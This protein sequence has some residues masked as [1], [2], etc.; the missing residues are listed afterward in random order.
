MMKDLYDVIVI[1]GGQAGLAAAYHLQKAELNFII[2]E[3]NS[4]HLGSWAKYYDSLKLF[5]PARYSALP[6]MKFPGDPDRYPTRNEVVQYLHA[7]AGHYQF[8]IH[9]GT[10]VEDIQKENGSFIITAADNKRYQ[11][12]AIICASGPFNNPYLPHITNME[13]FKGTIL[14]SKQYSNH[15]KYK[16]QRIIVVGGGSSAV[17]IAIELAK[18]ANV[19]I[20][21]RKPL[22]FVPQTFLGK[23]IHFWITVLGLDQS[24]WG[25]WLLG[26]NTTG[27]L[28]TGAYQRA[29]EQNKPN[30][31]HMFEQFSEEGVIWG[32]GTPEKVDTVLF[33]TGYLPNFTYLRNLNVLNSKGEP[34]H[35]DGVSTDIE[36]LYFAGLDWQRSFASATIRGVGKDAKYIVKQILTS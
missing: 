25:K 1:G 14:H 19:T 21:T 18:T 28:D 2:L 17:Q 10:Q 8:P 26:R 4:S 3:R 12:R 7:Y 13:T 5:S 16:G 22:K 27:V 34:N 32:D 9:Y 20:V 24:K 23:D 15:D 29:I 11:A 6:G 30:H 35:Q 36:G 33:A 31:K